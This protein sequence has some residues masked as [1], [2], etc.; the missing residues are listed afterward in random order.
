VGRDGE[1]YI[2]DLGQAASNVSEKQKL[3]GVLLEE[4]Q[5]RAEAGT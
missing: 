3:F 5:E 4:G 1:G 2:A